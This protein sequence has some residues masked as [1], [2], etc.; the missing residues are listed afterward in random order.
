VQYS[1]VG[2]PVVVEYEQGAG[3]IVWWASSTPL[4]NGF[5]QRGNNLH[6][7]LNSL[8]TREG[9]N[10]YWDESLHGEVRTQWFYARGLA[11]NLLLYGM[12]GI[13]LLIVFSFSRRRGPVRDL[14]QPA[15]ASSVEF[16]D[17]LGSLYKNAGAAHTA[18]VLAYDRFRRRMGLL[19]GLQGMQ[20]SGEE[21]AV[22][23]RRRFPQAHSDMEENLRTCAAALKE[24]DIAPKQ[25][26]LHIQALDRH[27]SLI[28]ALARANRTGNDGRDRWKR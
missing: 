13:A 7:L 22:H 23:L 10:F 9:H 12:A 24:D 18:L 5:I 16:L 6:L 28:S 8:G 3:H 21:M 2:S 26:L 14:P 27:E 20:M 15:R 17:A 19:C 1:C 4:E 11:L 25:A